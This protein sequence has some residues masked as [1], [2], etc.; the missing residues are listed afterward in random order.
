LAPL[1]VFDP[2]WGASY[3]P[4]LVAYGYNNTSG[5]ATTSFT[6]DDV[7]FSSVPLPPSTILLAPGLVGLA[8][9]REKFRKTR[10]HP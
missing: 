9:A 8:A 6:M 1:G 10:L 7:W 5:A 4:Y 3:D 2:G